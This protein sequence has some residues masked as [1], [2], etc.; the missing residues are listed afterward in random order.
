MHAVARLAL[1][2]HIQNIQTS[3]VKMGPDGSRACLQAGANDM[4]GTLMNETIT[5]SAGAAW[6]Q[7]LAPRQMEDLITSIARTPRQRTTLYGP[8]PGERDAVSRVATPLDSIVN[9]SP[10]PIKNK[11]IISINTSAS[12]VIN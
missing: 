12:R 3:W 6:G 10:Q 8:V 5:R 7:E 2:P 1:N 11:P 4:G 9:T